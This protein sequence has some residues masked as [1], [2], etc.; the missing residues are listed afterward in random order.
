[1]Y[2]SWYVSH[3]FLQCSHTGLL[4]LAKLDTR[5]NTGNFIFAFSKTAFGEEVLYY[6]SKG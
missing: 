5:G 2:I 3:D 1:M 6:V 4:E